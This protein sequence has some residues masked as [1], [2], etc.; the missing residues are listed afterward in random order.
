[1]FNS[2]GM[3][4]SS[5]DNTLIGWEAQAVQSNVNVTAFGV[6]YCAGKTA[7]QALIDDHSWSFTGDTK[8]TGTPVAICP[9]SVV[10]YLDAS[11]NGVLPADALAQGQS[12]TDCGGS[13]TETSP[14]TNFNCSHLG[15]QAVLLT[16]TGSGGNMT[17]QNCD[18]EIIDTIPPTILT[19]PAD[20]IVLTD[21]GICA[22]TN[23][24]FGTAT[25][26]DNC[27]AVAVALINGV[28][29]PYSF[30]V[31]ERG[32]TGGF[33]NG[34]LTGIYTDG[35]RSVVHPLAGA[36]GVVMD[37]PTS[38][39]ASRWGL[40]TNNL[41]RY[42]LL[43]GTVDT[44]ATLPGVVHGLD[45][46]GAGNVIVT[47]EGEGKIQQVHIGTGAVTDLVTGLDRP[48]DA[49]LENATSLL[50]SEY[51][52]GQ[53]VRYD[54]NTNT[55][56][57]ISTGHVG[58]TDILQPGNGKFLVAENGGHVAEVDSVS[59]GR[60]T[61]T[62][63]LG[64][65]PFGPH[66]LAMDSNGDLYITLYSDGT[67]VKKELSGGGG[68]STF[69]TGLKSPVYIVKSPDNIMLPGV[70]TVVWAAIDT[71]GN[72]DFCFQEVTVS[73]ATCPNNAETLD[74]DGVDDYVDLG[75]WT[76]H[77]VDGFTHEAW[78]YAQNL[79]PDDF[80]NSII[81]QEG[82]SG[83]S[84]ILRC[85]Q[86]G[87]NNV[88]ASYHHSGGLYDLDGVITTNNWHH[89]AMTWN[90]VVDTF[91]LYVDG[92]L[93]DE[94]FAPNPPNMVSEEVWIGNSEVAPD[95]WFDGRIDEVRVWDHYRT[96]AE[97]QA[98][99]VKEL[100]GLEAGLLA[101]Y[102]FNQGNAFLD[103]PTVTTLNDLTGNHSGTLHNFA[104]TVGDNSN[105]VEPGPLLG[106]SKSTGF[107]TTWEAT[108]DDLD[109]EIPTVG[110]YSYSYTVDWGDGII[111]AGVT[112]EATHTYAVP[113]TYTV[114]IDGV[115]PAIYLFDDAANALQ[116]K[117]IEQWGDI[118][119]A[120]FTSAFENAQ[121]M[122]LNTTDAPDLSNV[123]NMSSMLYN[124]SNFTGDLNHWDLSNVNFIGY[125][126]SGSAFNGDV[127]NWNTSFVV[128]MG[129][130]FAATPFNGSV[131]N[132]DVSLV[133][134]MAGMFDSNT[135]FNQPLGNWERVGSSLSNV[136]DIQ[137]MFFGATAFNQNI[138]NWNVSSVQSF[139]NMFAGANSFNQPLN[140][141][142]VGS[143][144]EMQG[145][146]YNASAFDQPLNSWDVVDV[147]NMF[148][149]FEG[150][151]S[152][153]QDISGWAVSNVEDMGW[154]FFN[155]TAFN[156]SLGSWDITNVSRM[157]SMFDS[158]G[159]DLASYDAILTGWA[160]QAPKIGVPVGGANMRFCASLLDRKKL[161]DDF[162]W[163]FDGDAQGP[164]CL[165][166]GPAESLCFDGV[167]DYV[168]LPANL[169]STYSDFT[170]M[171]WYYNGSTTPWERIMDFGSDETNWMW[172]TP[173]NTGGVPIFNIITGGTEN[174]LISPDA[175]VVDQWYHFA[176]TI[177]GTSDISTLYINGVQ[178][179][180]NTSA[181]WSPSDLGNTP[182][183]WLGRSNFAPDPYLNGYLDEV[184]IWNV[185]LDSAQVVNYMNNELNGTEGGLQHYYQFN[186]G[187]AFGNN[188]GEDTL[189]DELG[190]GNGT[191]HNFTL[192]GNCSNWILPGSG[193]GSPDAFVT[194]WET[195]TANESITIPTKS[196][197]VY[198]Y[199]VDWGDGT[200][201]TGNAG[202]ATHSY[203]TAGL[204]TVS[205]RGVFPRIHF[206]NANGNDKLKIKS[207]EQWGDIAWEDMIFAFG[208][209]S[210]MAYHA[211]DAPDL[212]GV[213]SL[214]GM[215]YGCYSFTSGSLSNWDLST[216]TDIST[217]FAC[218][219]FDGDVSGW[220]TANITS[221]NCT[222][223]YD[224]FNGDVS[225][226]DVSSV[227]NMRKMFAGNKHFN[228]EMSDWDVS[229]VTRMDE[230]FDVAEKFN[231]Y[232]GDWDVSSVVNMNS[233]FG[234]TKVFNQDISGWDVSNVKT[235]GKM[236]NSAVAF[237]QDIGNWNV[238]K[239][240]FMRNMF[241]GATAFNQDIGAWDVSEVSYFLNMFTN[242]SSF[243]QN[244][245]AWQIS[246]GTDF[247]VMF[248]NCGMSVENYDN[249][250]IGWAGQEDVPTNREI[251]VTGL[252]FCEGKLS[253]DYLILEKGWT[254]QGDAE[255]A[256]CSSHCDC[257]PNTSPLIPNTAGGL[258]TAA[259]KCEDGDFTHYCDS[260][261]RLLLSLG[262]PQ[263]QTIDP[264]DLTVSIVP[265]TQY[266]PQ[267][268][269]GTGGSE[270]GS[271]FVINSSGWTFLCRTWD[272]N[273]PETDAHVR[274]YFDDTDLD[275]INAATDSL[276]FQ[277]KAEPN[278]LWMYKVT[279]AGP[280]HE[281]PDDL[282]TSD[283][284][285]IGP[286]IYYGNE[287][288]TNH[289]KADTTAM[290][291]YSAE[292]IV[293][294]FSG[295]GGG[296][297]DEGS[298]PDCPVIK[299][300]FSG[301]TV[302][303]APGNGDVVL[304]ITGGTG[305]YDLS[306][307]N[308]TTVNGYNPGD[309]ISIFADES[310][311]FTVA[312]LVDADN[313][314][315]T[316]VIGEGGIYIQSDDDTPPMAICQDVTVDIG[317]TGEAII[318]AQDVDNGSVDNDSLVSI[319]LDQY[320]F[321]CSSN[322][323]DIVTLTATDASG[324]F[325]TCSAI[326]TIN[327]PNTFCCPAVRNVP[328]TA[329]DDT[330]LYEAD[331]QITSDAEVKLGT[332]NTNIIFEAGN[333]VQLNAGFEVEQGAVFEAKIGPCGTN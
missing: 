60:T 302:L 328:N 247:R 129:G 300:V 176:V 104:L 312:T 193:I 182:N 42:D 157:T 262:N 114:S 61:I 81:L 46:D 40:F 152:F 116:L 286:P 92:N 68:I 77:G 11:G 167:D 304:T 17:T 107:I 293:S 288:A 195:T 269:T 299:G 228:G 28:T 34:A 75:I 259:I 236:F 273:S 174:P 32:T 84:T 98:F 103:N 117:S 76:P 35:T 13:A 166:G 112:G 74:F 267:N 177:D 139:S 175:L 212:S 301:I 140:T 52:F 280:G 115:F 248:H 221:M 65:G 132:W 89:L 145:M 86:N 283:I 246:N 332:G 149:M 210:N 137:Y 168:E 170:F 330:R 142:D 158:S 51:N 100:N 291:F 206:N 314:P 136:L 25:V 169:V 249:T 289:Y 227:T 44:I 66:G 163:T 202:D 204:Y 122:V 308:G 173:Q 225:D 94:I 126:F 146:F 233:M 194:T 48:V 322:G 184:S 258:H 192:D 256:D 123:H 82:P 324:N 24:D 37:S 250:L 218:S 185:P 31:G 127:S 216:V 8:D 179:A 102:N 254:F 39:I 9:S 251:G 78:V 329:V 10:V 285:L 271:C 23:I 59:G 133:L 155:A 318:T 333:N 255:D 55:P 297:G 18:V 62:P 238:S 261:G 85:G 320:T 278:T 213:T 309:P 144:F 298:G 20:T 101:Y 141:W 164:S 16:V 108:L 171:A 27:S 201:A 36:D 119:W 311:Q 230:M 313:C 214:E 54:L 160:T 96:P 198:N 229:S 57:V 150:A 178:K 106:P 180:Q 217:T 303:P 296:G 252:K 99:M 263:A 277:G 161:M 5:Y 282:K 113:G 222:F 70:N 53:I 307:S 306:L 154:M 199:I 200:V 147:E 159:V 327:D 22:A 6:K 196:G 33:A 45:Y 87:P 317:S 265:G 111:D 125:M 91:Y 208:G 203:D 71:S 64:G 257:N 124:C 281:K 240:F 234:R 143:A 118:E 275:I 331:Q 135:A 1:M 110:S 211:T 172:L 29:P 2:S 260:Q 292:Y 245:G 80:S 130:L 14:L 266:Y 305:P 12:P 295:G 274:Y 26:D 191:F 15:F 243:D 219:A 138:S 232:I 264:A 223:C 109:I 244:L 326:V 162:G 205:I 253:R 276:G 56:T 220:N 43:D 237:N 30:F 272:V 120:S 58:P 3:G 319:I 67:I 242:A 197:L 90:P 38:V 290:G 79:G 97:I 181:N 241:G 189:E 284:V 268:C 294:S 190:T 315:G 156:Q 19:C 93:A 153:N 73:S 235:M 226:W 128:D 183:N 321:G 310:I 279:A 287:P 95:R 41:I 69:A 224:P 207:I 134:N 88:R 151:V 72:F 188:A 63:S 121:N 239:V 209:C 83:T 215:F 325:E 4:I 21:P 270:D 47:N 7:R 131:E 50:I 187:I 148:Y 165:L 186:Q 231:Q 105:W 316:E 49:I 323:S